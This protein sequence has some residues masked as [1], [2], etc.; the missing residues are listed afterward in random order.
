[1]SGS[2]RHAGN[3]KLCWR[4][5][6]SFFFSGLEK[7]L[8]LILQNLV[9]GLVKKCLPASSAEQDPI[10]SLMMK[11]LFFL[12]AF[13]VFAFFKKERKIKRCYVKLVNF[14]FTLA[15]A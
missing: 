2:C 9:V 6:S 15:H 12:V 4:D 3:N 10:Q 1:L 7:L 5:I 14:T 8:A 13:P 11:Y